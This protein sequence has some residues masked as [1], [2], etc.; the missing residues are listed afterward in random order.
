MGHRH[1]LFVFYVSC[2]L[3][4]RL[5]PGSLATYLLFCTPFFEILTG[6]SGDA[7][8]Q[9]NFQCFSQLWGWIPVFF[10]APPLAFPD[11]CSSGEFSK[12]VAHSQFGCYVT[13]STSDSKPYKLFTDL[14][15]FTLWK[16]IRL[17]WMPQSATAHDT[18]CNARQCF[19]DE[20][21]MYMAR[22]FQFPFFSVGKNFCQLRLLS[23]KDSELDKF[24]FFSLWMMLR[25][26]IQS[27]MGKLFYQDTSLIS[28]SP[29]LG[30][31]ILI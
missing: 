10:M 12:D 2:S 7:V 3:S 1:L 5:H 21:R 14:L 4:V 20:W 23:R 30:I 15:L 27:N 22:R 16:R 11:P 24:S 26:I 13:C 29:P 31:L 17:F 9:W 28:P 19:S 25:T 8:P 18:F 6:S